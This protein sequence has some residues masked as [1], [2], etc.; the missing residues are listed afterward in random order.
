[1]PIG[2][3]K[4]REAP[5]FEI[6]RKE[7]HRRRID[8]DFEY[9][10][11]CEATSVMDLALLKMVK[12]RNASLTAQVPRDHRSFEVELEKR[13]ADAGISEDH[14]TK[15]ALQLALMQTSDEQNWSLFRDHTEFDPH[16]RT[17]S[18]DK[19]KETLARLAEYGMFTTVSGRNVKITA[20]GG[21]RNV[22]FNSS[23]YE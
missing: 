13:I 21:L 2:L 6:L 22:L 8:T 1:M 3:F 10:V 11:P 16:S 19:V 5:S 14:Y 17:F 12:E 20:K 15:K 9:G 4:W 23:L 18:I 7:K